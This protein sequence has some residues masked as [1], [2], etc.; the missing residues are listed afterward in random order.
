MT[1]FA[2]DFATAEPVGGGWGL[3]FDACVF[4][5]MSEALEPTP[6]EVV[7]SCCLFAGPEGFGATLVFC[8]VPSNDDPLSI[9]PNPP[10]IEC[11]DV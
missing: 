9:E 3:S 4:L 5:I 1:G 6:E 7:E 8:G 11:F 2:S 10:S